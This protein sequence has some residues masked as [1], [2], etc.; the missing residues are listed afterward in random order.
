MEHNSER[1]GF[2][3]YPCTGAAEILQSGQNWG[4]GRGRNIS[5]SGCYVETM[6]PLP[7]GTEVQLGIIINGVF[8]D[9][10]ANVVFSDPMFGMGVEFVRTE[11]W[12]KLKQ[13]A[14]SRPRV[15][16][17]IAFKK[18]NKVADVDPSPS[19]LQDG[20]SHEEAQFQMQ[21]VLQHLQQA[22]KEVQEATRTWQL[23]ENAIHE[24]KSVCKRGSTVE[25]TRPAL[26]G[27]SVVWSCE[28]L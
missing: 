7:T 13:A 25:T 21:A 1:R 26:M 24:V 11:Q 22:Q 6:Y 28:A 14:A 16:G 2:S 4:W 20:A 12:N 10:C 3:R 18:V 8:L 19:L 9:L 27:N 17:A 5:C 15:G 23:I